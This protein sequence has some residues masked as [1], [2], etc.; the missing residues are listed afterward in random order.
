VRHFSID[1]IE[2]YNKRTVVKILRQRFMMLLKRNKKNQ[3]QDFKDE[4]AEE[5]SV[6][7]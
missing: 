4:S 7:R 5:Y 2:N 6:F 3:A 1:A